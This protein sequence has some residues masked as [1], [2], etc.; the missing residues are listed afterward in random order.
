[1]GEE[2]GEERIW[3]YKN[4]FL[5]LLLGIEDA[6]GGEDPSFFEFDGVFEPEKSPSFLTGVGIGSDPRFAERVG[7]V[8]GEI[9]FFIPPPP[10]TVVDARVARAEGVSCIDTGRPDLVG[11]GSCEKVN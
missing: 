4:T 9:S 8:A 6:T 1:M 10:P 2:E 3:K 7:E 11:G 5:E